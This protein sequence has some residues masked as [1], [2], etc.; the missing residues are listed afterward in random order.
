MVTLDNN[1]KVLFWMEDVATKAD[2]DRLTIY[3]SI[4][5]A[6]SDAWS[7]EQALFENEAY[8]GVPAIATDGINIGVVWQ[9]ASR[10]LGTSGEMEKL[11]GCLDLWYTEFDGKSFSDP[12]CVSEQG[13]GLHKENYT[14]T[15]KGGKAVIAWTENSEND[16]FGLSGTNTLY[17]RSIESGLE[18][19]VRTVANTE[20]SIADVTLKTDNEGTKLSYR[21]TNGDES[22]LYIE[23]DYGI[24]IPADELEKML[25]VG[26]VITYLETL[27]LPEL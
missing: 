27:D 1:N 13:N 9:R 26:D 10:T 22:Q 14:L 23:D 4:Y 16:I 6:E 17:Q 5:D 11:M 18:G 8:N 21:L 24:E 25:T 2:D 20:S 7:S 3:Y 12:V 19:N 15:M